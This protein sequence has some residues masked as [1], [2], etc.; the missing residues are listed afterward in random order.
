M[1][2]EVVAFRYLRARLVGN[3]SGLNK[4]VFGFVTRV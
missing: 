1:F 2:C 4:A 3:L